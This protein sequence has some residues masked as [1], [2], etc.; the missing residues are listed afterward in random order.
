MKQSNWWGRHSCLPNSEGRQE[1][2]PHHPWVALS[3]FALLALGL[4]IPVPAAWAQESPRYQVGVL[5][6][7]TSQGMLVQAVQSGFPAARAGLQRG[8]L[9]VKIDGS[10]ITSQSD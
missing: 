2:L 3:L 1:C 10:T 8:D 9:I 4:A 6:Q 5:G 7:Y